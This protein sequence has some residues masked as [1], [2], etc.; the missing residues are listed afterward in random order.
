M[1]KLG[2]VNEGPMPSLTCA[3]LGKAFIIK[4]W[5]PIQVGAGQLRSRIRLWASFTDAFLKIHIADI[6]LPE[7]KG[8]SPKR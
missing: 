5:P 4:T 7:S 1:G 6:A 3:R 2:P 8:S